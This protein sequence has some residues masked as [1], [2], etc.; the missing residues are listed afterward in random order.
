MPVQCW[1][2]LLPQRRAEPTHLQDTSQIGRTDSNI[3]W[4]ALLLAPVFW[5]V[6]AFVALISLKFTW[7]PLPAIA[8]MLSCSNVL[9][10]W[11]CRRDAKKQAK[12]LASKGMFMALSQGP[13]FVSSIMSG[14]GGGGGGGDAAGSAAADATQPSDA[15]LRAMQGEL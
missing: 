8:L 5:A 6:L 3:F 15:Q 7:I 11:R 12:E 10:Y 1:F 4:G 2:L 14:L 13:G 9:G